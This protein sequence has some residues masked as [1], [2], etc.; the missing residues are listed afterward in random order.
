MKKRLAR[1][2]GGPGEQVTLGRLEG[3]YSGGMAAAALGGQLGPDRTAIVRVVRAGDELLAFEPVHELRDV[4]A[5]T[6][7]ALGQRAQRKRLTGGDEHAEHLVLGQRQ[8]ERLEGRVES[9]LDR[10]K[11]P[12]QLG[13][14]RCVRTFLPAWNIPR[15]WITV[16]LE[17]RLIGRA[18]FMNRLGTL[19]AALGLL[20]VASCHT[21]RPLWR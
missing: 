11:G 4:R 2:R 8:P 13:G 9:R 12:D 14:E 17:S 19:L 21:N 5:H 7:G 10:V 6:R 3:P 20:A 18:A 16:K 15:R 1:L